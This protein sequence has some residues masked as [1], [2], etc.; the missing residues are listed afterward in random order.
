MEEILNNSISDNPPQ[1]VCEL[2][3]LVEMMG[4]KKSLIKGIMDAFLI[5]IPEELL[6][7]NN[8]IAKA[9]YTMIKN[10]AHSMKSSLSI[11][12]ISVTL[13][14]LTEMELLGAKGSEIEKIKELNTYLNIMCSKALEE[15]EEDKHNYV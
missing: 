14:I 10:L 1:T 7:I 6:S 5:Q 13:P 8:A 12:G 4:S 15:V 2:K 9:D 11:M 3:Y